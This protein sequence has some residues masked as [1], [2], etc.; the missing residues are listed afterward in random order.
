ML[1]DSLKFEDWRH[2]LIWLMLSLSPLSQSH[3]SGLLSCLVPHCLC[4]SSYKCWSLVLFEYPLW[5][6]L[7]FLVL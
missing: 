3:I 6:P 1:A 4:F 7:V 5:L 2:F